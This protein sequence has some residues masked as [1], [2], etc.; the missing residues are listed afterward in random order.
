MC[1]KFLAFVEC[2][3]PTLLT[4]KP[5]IVESICDPIWPDPQKIVSIGFIVLS[6]SSGHREFQKKSPQIG[7]QEGS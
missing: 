7:R 1:V 5:P 6:D 4:K 2:L 3:H